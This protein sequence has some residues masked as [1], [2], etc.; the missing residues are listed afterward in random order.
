MKNAFHVMLIPT[1]GCPARCSYCWSS[2][3]GSP[4]MTIE[5]VRE[6]VEWLK[7]FR[8]DRV[9]ITFHGGEPLLAGADFYRQV[10]PMLAEGL[11][12]LKPEFALQSN[13][14]KLTPELADVLAQYNV[15]VGSSID[16]PQE[17]CD[18][19]RGAGY[20]AK[21][22]KGYEIAKAHGVSVRFICTFT[23][24]SVKA[25]EEIFG[26]FLKNRF[27]LKLH[28][29]LPSLRN[30]NPD[31]WALSPPEYGELLV[32]L[33]DQ[34]LEH[35]A[36][37]DIMNINDLVRCVFT[38]RGNVCTFANCMGNTFAVGPDGLI[39]P[40]YR[41]IGMPEYVMGN[42][43]DHPDLATL[44]DSPAGKLMLQYKEF[45]DTAC[46]SCRHIKYCRGGCPYNAIAPTG[47]KIESVDPHCVAYKR[48]FDEI[49]DRLNAEMFGDTDFE[50]AGFGVPAAKGSK[51]K[52]IT[53]MHKIVTR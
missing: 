40:C 44:M 39:Y 25:K 9:T 36:E 29:A 17:I 35:A 22:M 5:T 28:P 2:E 3:E 7:H 42:V 37:I 34:A 11:H 26:F 23:S 51:P 46:G 18:A 15:P 10:L 50:M 4:I 33:L 52:I 21:T 1:L 6:V 32:Y 13:L 8:S 31:Q 14:W 27:T 24:R 20:F 38:R 41:F 53:L 12:D 16:G 47:G 43:A 48:I 49:S 45:V 30:N 19:Q